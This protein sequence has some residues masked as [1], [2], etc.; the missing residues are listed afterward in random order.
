[1]AEVRCLVDRHG[2]VP[3]LAVVMVGDDPASQIYV[4]AKKRMVAESGMRSIDHRLPAS[5]TREELLSLV[6]ALNRDLGV[7]G[8]LVQLQLPPHID[9]A[10]VIGAIP[11]K[12]VDGFHPLNVGRIVTG[13]PGLAPCTPLGCVALAK[14]VRPSLSGLDAVVVGRSNIVG[15]PLAQ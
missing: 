3:G 12:D 6:D 10:D 5:T 8:I 14:T 11:G 15:K 4:G 9:S 13:L 7:H 1:S 2:I